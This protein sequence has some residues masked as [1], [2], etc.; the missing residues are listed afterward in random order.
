MI[1]SELELM[2]EKKADPQRV[3]DL[4]EAWMMGP[5]VDDLA[6]KRSVDKGF[7]YWMAV[8]QPFILVRSNDVIEKISEYLSDQ[9]YFAMIGVESGARTG[10][11]TGSPHKLRRPMML[12]MAVY[13][14]NSESIPASSSRWVPLSAE[15][16]SEYIF[17]SPLYSTSD[18]RELWL[19]RSGAIDAMKDPKKQLEAFVQLAKD[20]AWL[21]PSEDIAKK[22]VQT[23][24]QIILNTNA[25]DDADPTT[26]SL[27]TMDQLTIFEAIFHGTALWG[28]AARPVMTLLDGNRESKRLP[29]YLSQSWQAENGFET[30]PEIHGT[31]CV[32]IYSAVEEFGREVAGRN[33]QLK[34]ADLVDA[35]YEFSKLG[36][37]EAERARS[38][39]MADQLMRTFVRIRPTEV[40]RFVL[41][42]ADERL[43]AVRD[44]RVTAYDFLDRW[45]KEALGGVSVAEDHGDGAGILPNPNGTLLAIHTPYTDSYST[46]HAWNNPRALRLLLSSAQYQDE[47]INTAAGW[48]LS[49]QYAEG[50]M[51]GLRDDEGEFVLLKSLD[52]DIRQKVLA[53]ALAMLESD[54]N[55]FTD[56]KPMP[57]PQFYA[58]A[59][60]F[61]G[62]AAGGSQD[63]EAIVKRILLHGALHDPSATLRD[64]EA[65]VS[66]KR[67][68][69]VKFYCAAILLQ[70][71][72]A[73]LLEAY[74][75][76]PDKIQE[77]VFLLR[78]PRMEV[79]GAE[80]W[81]AEYTSRL[82]RMRVLPLQDTGVQIKGMFGTDHWSTG[83]FLSGAQSLFDSPRE[84]I[85]RN[86]ER[87]PT[88][89]RRIVLSEIPSTEWLRF[90]GD[91]TEENLIALIQLMEHGNGEITSEE[92]QEIWREFSGDRY[93]PQIV[94]YQY[95]RRRD[96][97][98]VQD[99]PDTVKVE[100]RRSVLDFLA[101]VANNNVPNK[102]RAFYVRARGGKDDGKQG[103]DNRFVS[104]PVEDVYR[105]W[106]Q[107][108]LNLDD[109]DRPHGRQA[110]EL[111]CGMTVDP[112]VIIG[113]SEGADDRRRA[114]HKVIEVF[115]SDI[116]PEVEDYIRV[117]M[118]EGSPVESAIP[119]D[120]KALR[121]KI[122]FAHDLLLSGESKK[123]AEL[124]QSDPV[125]TAR[126]LI[127]IKVFYDSSGSA[128]LASTGIDWLA[129]YLE[130]L[131]QVHPGRSMDSMVDE[132]QSLRT[133]PSAEDYR[134]L[135]YGEQRSP[136]TIGNIQDANQLMLAAW[137]CELIQGRRSQDGNSSPW[138]NLTHLINQR[139]NVEFDWQ[140]GPLLRQFLQRWSAYSDLLL[141]PEELEVV[142]HRLAEAI[143][144]FVQAQTLAPDSTNGEFNVDDFISFLLL[145]ETFGEKVAALDGPML[146]RLRTS[147]HVWKGLMAKA[148]GYSNEFKGLL[149]GWLFGRDQDLATK[150]ILSSGLDEVE[151]LLRDRR[152]LET[153]RQELNAVPGQNRPGNIFMISLVGA[154]LDQA[155]SDPKGMQ[156]LYD[157]G[158]DLLE[159]QEF[160]DVDAQHLYQT[161]AK[162]ILNK[163]GEIIVQAHRKGDP[164]KDEEEWIKKFE[165]LRPYD[166]VLDLEEDAIT[167]LA[168]RS[169]QYSLNKMAQGLAGSG[170]ASAPAAVQIRPLEPDHL[171]ADQWKQPFQYLEILNSEG[172]PIA[173]LLRGDPNNGAGLRMEGEVSGKGVTHEGITSRNKRVVL[174]LPVG[175]SAGRATTD[176]LAVNGLIMVPMTSTTRNDG[177]IIMDRDG[178]AK[179]VNKQI[180]K[181][182]DLGPMLEGEPEGD[183]DKVF[184]MGKI[185]DYV[186]VH[187]EII[188]KNGLS[189]VSNMLLIDGDKRVQLNDGK[190]SRRLFVQFEDGSWGVLHMLEAGSTDAATALATNLKS[191]DPRLKVDKAVY[192][193]TGYF[194][195]FTIEWL[196][197]LGRSVHKKVYGHRDAEKR[198]THRIFGVIIEELRKKVSES[199]PAPDPAHPQ[200]AAGQL[201]KADALDDFLKR[202]IMLLHNRLF[203]A[204]NTHPLRHRFI[205]NIKR[206]ELHKKFN[207]LWQEFVIALRAD[208]SFK[209][210]VAEAIGSRIID[211][212]A[213]PSFALA[214]TLVTEAGQGARFAIPSRMAGILGQE[215]SPPIESSFDHSGHMNHQEDY[216]NLFEEFSS[217]ADQAGKKIVALYERS[218]A[219]WFDNPE[220][221]EMNKPY[222]SHEKFEARTFD[223]TPEFADD[224]VEY[225][226]FVPASHARD[227]QQDHP[228]MAWA[229]PGM[230]VVMVDRTDS[231]RLYA[232]SVTF[233]LAAQL[234]TRKMN[235]ESG[236]PDDKGQPDR[237]AI[238]DFMATSTFRLSFGPAAL[239]DPPYQAIAWMNKLPSPEPQT[240]WSQV[241]I[242]ISKLPVRTPLSYRAAL[243]AARLSILTSAKSA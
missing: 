50:T 243:N 132:L 162:F 161:V 200:A 70:R 128:V 90:L 60:S 47:A 163:V 22:M 139:E 188:P 190:D 214:G 179:V 29:R 175:F 117:L 215:L 2:L 133:A 195:W 121:S 140:Q 23:A 58:A 86:L 63:Q 194:D 36:S 37:T 28:E 207:V 88:H 72:F 242:M 204:V 107:L 137:G 240:G 11:A 1:R 152:S 138:V 39:S 51:G 238:N 177:W 20:A 237:R 218:I 208:P 14:E 241:F 211:E 124:A 167:K 226:V 56:H 224:S 174:S 24:Q 219:P 203:A 59:A 165:P 221:E 100:D 17:K 30:S 236:F 189:V 160:I 31:F 129:K 74:R 196:D 49:I 66:K 97:F 127:R 192:C 101:R 6:L 181:R 230:R 212:L 110:F 184:N 197:E 171:P 178:R 227:H 216:Q 10:M 169:G 102:F 201:W 231:D 156:K 76:S 103:I 75:Q 4:A 108:G 89:T 157:T 43:E 93:D 115:R 222:L 13:P 69:Y 134:T 71:D 84:K 68:M 176:T 118:N 193:D 7:R 130:H 154:Y 12:S 146:E 95:L 235:I 172:K 131:T 145:R 5:G 15:D 150:I 217:A 25:P 41:P 91:Q 112:N 67:G 183:R 202:E 8:E 168:T 111:L 27:V 223:G 151:A 104:G 61:L 116:I 144:Q 185:E 99:F 73:T 19:A 33:D 170:D 21:E 142:R 35:I 82:D 199:T 83:K 205:G 40:R 198:S 234:V 210:M 96:V 106:N 94:I 38:R 159:S 65:G 228:K 213:V 229:R 77:E 45:I 209:G 87:L 57:R 80:D 122:R 123:L 148:G 187:Y 16:V 114:L 141:L 109:L 46:H 62:Y 44:G 55:V 98:S 81:N 232:P 147:K 233:A 166:I 113:A 173:I 53:R 136:L 9:P 79:P 54:S 34:G 18:K 225:V 3:F 220:F 206:N 126:L 48:L 120:G 64:A 32:K 135:F 158:I 143:D 180:L 78:P 182:S 42:D 119:D 92:A 239:H 155:G 164:L 85:I 26:R 191:A 153:L 52:P 149:F 125:E 186:R 105:W